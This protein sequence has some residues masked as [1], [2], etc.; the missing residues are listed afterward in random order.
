MGLPVPHNAQMYTVTV[1]SFLHCVNFCTYLCN[2]SLLPLH[3]LL[4]TSRELEAESE[5]S[6]AKQALLLSPLQL[7]QFVEIWIPISEGLASLLAGKKPY[8]RKRCGKNQGPK[9]TAK[10]LYPCPATVLGLS[11]PAHSP[12]PH[13]ISSGPSALVTPQKAWWPAPPSPALPGLGPWWPGL[14]PGLTSWPSLGPSLSPRRCRFPGLGLPQCPL[15]ALLLAGAV[16][17]TLAARPFADRS[18]GSLWCSWTMTPGS[19]WLLLHPATTSRSPAC[20]LHLFAE[21]LKH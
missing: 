1:H 2:F 17:W 21:S 4:R 8:L 12:G 11:S 14:T 6:S 9:G 18:L 5:V 19:C 16:G 10:T 7:L 13:I 3:K 20:T 15:A